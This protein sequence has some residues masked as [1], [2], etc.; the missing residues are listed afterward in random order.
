[1]KIGSMRM[2]MSLAA[3]AACVSVLLGS[4][5]ATAP[6]V[7]HA[8]QFTADR[9]ER[10][11]ERK[12][13]TSPTR[14]RSTSPNR[15]L[16]DAFGEAVRVAE[17]P[18][19]SAEKERLDADMEAEKMAKVAEEK[20]LDAVLKEAKNKHKA[21]LKEAKAK[22]KEAEREAK[23]EAAA[24]E[25]YAKQGADS[26]SRDAEERA[27][28]KKRAAKRQAA[29]EKRDAEQTELLAGIETRL[30][31]ELGR[32]DRTFR[33]E[34]ANIDAEL[35]TELA[36]IRTDDETVRA[37][38]QAAA[39]WK[40][41]TIDEERQTDNKSLEDFQGDPYWRT[42]RDNVFKELQ[43]HLAAIRAEYE[44]DRSRIANALQ[45]KLNEINAEESNWDWEIC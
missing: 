9:G 8:L 20:R 21:A 3:G 30:S 35:E 31:T 7:V 43:T 41:V 23:Q 13:S 37:T 34:I 38:T 36:T 10:S 14:K 42:N 25:R 5:A 15:T 32:I 4:L 33:T 11:R 39:A 27:D 29:S 28:A 16:S 18:A 1:M 26:V 44:A 6:G 24:A 40:H 45:A 19:K 17:K 12:R 2:K 22:A